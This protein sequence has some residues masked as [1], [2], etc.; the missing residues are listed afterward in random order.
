MAYKLCNHGIVIKRYLHTLFEPIVYTHTMSLRTH[1]SFKGSDVGQK[2]IR[3]ILRINSHFNR[4][5]PNG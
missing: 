5:A 4:M 3:W 2:I 1:I